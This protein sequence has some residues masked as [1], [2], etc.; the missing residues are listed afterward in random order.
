MKK[1]YLEEMIMVWRRH[2]I[3]ID[4]YEVERMNGYLGEDYNI[5]NLTIDEVES[6]LNGD[7]ILADNLNEIVRGY[8]LDLVYDIGR[9]YIVYE[10]H[11][12]DTDFGVY[13]E[14]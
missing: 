7:D 1:F 6:I 12:E 9:T 3:E 8:W 14:N 10:D 2:E 4:E 11:I 5:R 13:K